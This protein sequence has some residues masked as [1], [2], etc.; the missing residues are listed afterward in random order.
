MKSKKKLIITITAVVLVLAIAGGCCW[1]FLGS[2][3]GEAV[4]VFMFSYVG[5]TEY[6]G[7]SQESYGPVTTDRIQTVFLSSTQT[8]TEVFVKDG[9]TVKK[10][11][12]LM[13]FDTTLSDIALERER[14]KVEKLKLDLEDAYDQLA[15]IKNMKPSVAPPSE[16]EEEENQGTA[17]TEPYSISTQTA[18]D[19]STSQ[20][21]LVC[22]LRD[23]T[24]MDDLL[25]NALLA[26]STDYRAKNAASAPTEPEETLPEETTP[27]DPTQETAAPTEPQPTEPQPT[28]PQ[29]TEPPAPAADPNRFYVVF[30][31]T[32]NNM[33]LGSTLL[34]QGM[35]IYRDPSSGNY[36]F[37][38]YD[39]SGFQDHTLAVPTEPDAPAPDY[40]SGFSADELAQMRAQQ[41][42][43]IRDLQ[44]QVKVAEADYK[45]KQT[46]VSDGNIYAKIDGTVIANLSEE[47]AKLG[48]QPFMKVSG[49][50]G[51]YI[52]GSISELDRENLEL[53]QEVT[54]NDWN[55]G[56]TY[57]GTVESVGDHPVSSD[58]F[59]GIGNPNS[60]YYP[61]TVF[62][63][64][65]ADLQEGSYVSV[66]YSVASAEQGVY[67]ENPFLRTEDGKSFVYLRGEDGTLEKRYVTTGKSLWGSYTQILSGLTAED[68][69]A[70]PYGKTVKEGA[71]TE[72][73]DLSAL[74]DY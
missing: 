66:M 65:S 62:I 46:E 23:G 74:Y 22:W 52:E 34:W 10:G 33:S 1:Y 20:L 53:G 42:K 59:S 71:P 6:W 18:F 12:L 11:D 14:L 5:M 55:T 13:T 64:G 67:L 3:G 48:G 29:P 7:D 49:G 38:F 17:L 57:T 41:E 69:I 68:Y 61:F 44:F 50:G 15:D 54:V 9:D 19:G 47:D 31:M 60:S 56:M 58:Y 45:I 70:F 16:P 72:E 36:S 21:A 39:A 26:V 51:F 73:S 63:D 37:R 27:Q 35:E 4:P 25:M 40:G 24:A 8:V 43:V 28:E 32:Q 2:R 30:K